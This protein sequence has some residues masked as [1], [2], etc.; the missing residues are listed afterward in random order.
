MTTWDDALLISDRA[1]QTVFGEVAVYRSALDV[2]ISLPRAV[3]SNEYSSIDGD[4]SGVPTSLPALWVR[5]DD[6]P[7]DPLSDDGEVTVAGFVY[8]VIDVKPDGEGG[9]WL[10]LQKI[11]PAP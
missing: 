1:V 9:A 11:G 3:F 7:V 2:T 5:L 10:V 8:R 4:E 6:L